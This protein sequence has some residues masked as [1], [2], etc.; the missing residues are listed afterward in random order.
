M[1]FLA[2]KGAWDLAVVVAGGGSRPRELRHDH[3]RDARGNLVLDLG[4][5]VWGLGFRAEGLEFRVLGLEFGA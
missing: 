3:Q 2:E 4:F 5:R 1:N